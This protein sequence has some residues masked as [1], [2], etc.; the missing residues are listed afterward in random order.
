MSGEFRHKLRY[1]AIDGGGTKTAFL[2]ADENG[3]ELNSVT[4]GATN[5]NDVGM[6][7]TK[8]ILR[9]GIR[10]L[11]ADVCG[12][13]VLYAG[14]AGARTGSNRECL[15]RFLGEFGF[16][17]YDC[18]SDIDN[19]LALGDCPQQIFMI[20]GTGVNALVKREDALFR[21]AGWGQLFDGAGSGYD[22]GRDAI[23]AALYAFDGTGPQTMLSELLRRELGAEAADCLAA[24]YAGGKRYIASFARLVFEA[25]S[26]GDAVAQ[27]I[28][29]RNVGHIARILRAGAAKLNTSPVKVLMTGGLIDAQ[30]GIILPLLAQELGAGFCLTRSELPPI[31]GALRLAQ[32]E[33]ES[34]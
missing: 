12:N 28:L 24:F 16:A 10:A 29:Q 21:I 17:S 4:L 8:E 32:K 22:L 6:E 1:L 13:V 20:L 31:Y 33:K 2:L 23:R 9:Q 5:P 19:L 7:K 14:I 18:G 3:R 27:E 25:A 15:C 30:H 34:C 26:R 11:C